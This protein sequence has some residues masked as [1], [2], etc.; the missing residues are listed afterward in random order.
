MHGGFLPDLRSILCRRTCDYLRF[1][2]C[3]LIVTTTLAGL[4]PSGETVRDVARISENLL[5]HRAFCESG[6]Q[7]PIRGRIGGPKV[8]HCDLCSLGPEQLTY[9]GAVLRS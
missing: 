3:S 5:E 2:R 8:K 6:S 4:L 1:G 7:R 9:V